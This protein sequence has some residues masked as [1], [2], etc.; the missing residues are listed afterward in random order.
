MPRR[1]CVDRRFGGHHWTW[2]RLRA[3]GWPGRVAGEIVVPAEVYGWKASDGD[4]WRAAEVQGRNRVAFQRAFGEGLAVV[5]F[6]RDGAG[7]GIYQLGEWS[8]ADVQGES[9]KAGRRAGGGGRK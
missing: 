6:A 2:R 8:K 9:A 1:F 7:N 4:R 5:G 3:E